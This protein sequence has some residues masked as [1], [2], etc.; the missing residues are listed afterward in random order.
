MGDLVF[1]WLQ[2][3]KKTS[4]K[5]QGHQKLSPKLYGPYQILQCIGTMAY[6]LALPDSSK[7]QP[8]FHVSCLK[9]VVG[10]NCQV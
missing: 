3:Y 10:P 1:L 8:I 7:I 2:P 5:V 6:E 4:L 9:K